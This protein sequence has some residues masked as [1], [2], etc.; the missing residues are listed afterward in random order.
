MTPNPKI[1]E[2]DPATNSQRRTIIKKSGN[3][4]H[5]FQ[6]STRWCESCSLPALQKKKR[7]NHRVISEANNRSLSSL[8]NYEAIH[9]NVGFRELDDA[10]KSSDKAFD[11]TILETRSGEKEKKHNE[12]A[13]HNITTGRSFWPV[14]IGS[15]FW[16]ISKECDCA[17]VQLHGT[18]QSIQ[19]VRTCIT[20]TKPRSRVTVHTTQSAWRHLLPANAS[21]NHT[22]PSRPND[23]RHRTRFNLVKP[24]TFNHR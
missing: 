23:N 2:N 19:L 4:N 5:P 13:L 11:V 15:H 7:E 1:T 18:F 10:K 3:F 20:M 6:G 8:C 16:V 9:R 24:T 17:S 21:M 14:V 22:L 12:I